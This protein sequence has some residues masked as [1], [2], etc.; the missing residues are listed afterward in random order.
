MDDINNLDPNSDNYVDDYERLRNDPEL[1]TEMLKEELTRYEKALEEE[2]NVKAEADPEN[3]EEYTSDFFRKNAHFAAAQIVWLALNAESETVKGNMSKY[4]L[5]SAYRVEKE[6]KD[7]IA[8]IIE[9]L[10][11]NDNKPQ[12]ANREDE[13]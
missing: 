7:P 2:M 8:N 1:T 4:I 10:K 12:P 6:N 11:K 9:S 13:S 5:E 3:V